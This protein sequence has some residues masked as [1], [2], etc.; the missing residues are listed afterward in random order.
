M[1]ANTYV[2]AQQVTDIRQ[3]LYRLV[4]RAKI[5]RA[6]QQIQAHTIEYNHT[7]SD[8]DA[9]GDVRFQQE[10]ELLA[11]SHLHG[12]IRAN[13]ASTQGQVHFQLIPSHANGS[14]A[15]AHL[16]DANRS[17]Y[18]QVHY[19][20]CAP[21]HHIW[22][23][24]ANTLT[25]NKATGRM[26]AHD[27]TMRIGNVP[28]LYFPYLSL[29]ITQR[30]TSGFLYPTFGH[31]SRSGYL[32]GMPYYL[33]LAPNYDATLE[34]R[35]Y[36][37]RG[38][39]L[40]G[41]FRYMLPATHGQLDVQYVPKDHFQTSR[42][43]SIPH[44]ARRRKRW[45]I[46][47]DHSS[48][49]QPG[50]YLSANINRASDRH[51]LHDFGNS[52]ETM[53]TGMLTSS[54][55]L[56]GTTTHLDF[57]FGAD[58]YQNVDPTLPDSVLPYRRW[59]RA[60]LK[61]YLPLNRSL[62]IGLD[63][64]AV[65]FHKDKAVQG[66][67]LDVYPYI[68]ANFQGYAWFLRPRF[69]WRYTRYQL[70]PDYQ[71]NG[72][73]GILAKTQRSP[74][75][76]RTPS[77]SLPIISLDGGLIFERNT[78][79]LGKLYTQTLEPRIYYLYAPYREQSQLPL[80]DTIAMNFDYWQLFWPNRY[81]G[82]DR[83]MN[84]NNLSIAVQTLLL[85]QNGVENLG[86]RVGQIRYFAPQRV[87]LTGHA[88]TRFSGSNY[89]LQLDSR[90][91]DNWHMTSTYQWNPAKHQTHLGSIELQHYFGVGGV[92]NVSYRYQHKRLAQYATSIIYPFAERWHLLGYMTYSSRA[93]RT[94]DAMA[95]VQYAN[96]CIKI[97]LLGRHY[98][99]GYDHVIKTL[100]TH[101]ETA[102]AMMFNIE[103]KGI[104]S[105]NNQTELFLHRGILGY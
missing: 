79:L 71:H 37:R 101:P 65:A 26:V 40:A 18:S 55:Y 53:A 72:Y 33:N 96:C 9:R 46:T 41:Q 39:M 30:R 62:E 73:D 58:D 45:L 103:F 2:Q 44:Q 11:T 4:G 100:N 63:S 84:A 13:H 74:F 70:D 61:A 17:R 83:Q 86:L 10:G 93:R 36:S 80:F 47:Y 60:T 7:S 105:L 75:H 35:I 95:G 29:P 32:F 88:I 69:A 68:S 27:A 42:V 19:S 102:N 51:Y 23:I 67:R 104:G 25:V 31:T 52:L 28:F 82:A 64:E 20:T 98:I 50:W 77:R 94:I 14:A 15:Q 76:Q 81:S 89:V 54:A 97:S 91:S 8:Y 24:Q 90:L 85:D 66:Q 38:I 12:N 6:D 48:E 56:H 49:L 3:S 87:P 57:S 99:T 34:P 59:P 78:S 43:H 16:L 1:H 92:M 22:E 5:T 21:G